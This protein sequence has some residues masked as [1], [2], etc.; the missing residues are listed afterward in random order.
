MSSFALK[1]LLS[2]LVLPPVFSILLALLG[3]VIAR[4]HR[5]TGLSLAVASL[6]SVLV[7]SWPPVADALVRSLERPYAGGVTAQQLARAQAIVVLG[8][9]ADM[10]STESGAD[11][12]SRGARE[13]VRQ[14]VA[15]Q[16]QTGLPM[17][18]AGGVLGEGRPEAQV[19]QE[20]V[21]REY[22]GRVRWVEGQSLDTRANAENSARLLRAARIER[23]ALVTHGWH[24]RRAVE[25]FERQ[26]L[27]VV[28][29][30]VALRGPAPHA[31]FR[32]L[33]RVSALVDSN[34]ALHEW[35]GIAVQRW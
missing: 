3:L 5:R 10:P 1:K 7:L 23:I 19:M 32:V 31:L 29:V 24:M 2:A 18:T 16:R 26:G 27:E 21:Q 11:P 17:L 4:Y 12:L 33:P 9:G 6:L 22:K 28:P 13:R 25:L 15:L 30:P 20:V 35:L 34:L 14:A 8:G